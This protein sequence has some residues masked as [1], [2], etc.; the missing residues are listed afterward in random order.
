M[1]KSYCVDGK[2][3]FG[4][5]KVLVVQTL[6]KIPH[7][8]KNMPNSKRKIMCSLEKK[9]LSQKSEADLFQTKMK[10]SKKKNLI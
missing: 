8:R 5:I 3:S 6:V 10:H 1:K 4:K 2:C 9:F 7:F